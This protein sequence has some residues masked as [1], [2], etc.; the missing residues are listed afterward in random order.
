[1]VVAYDRHGPGVLGPV[2]AAA[3]A[4]V[5]GGARVEACAFVAW[6]AVLGV[7]AR[8]P[9]GRCRCIRIAADGVSSGVALAALKA[10]IAVLSPECQYS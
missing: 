8:R 9:I 6:I 7:A 2:A 3:F 1:V 10:L 5:V 4:V